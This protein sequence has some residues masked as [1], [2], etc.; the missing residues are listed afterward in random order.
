VIDVGG[1]LMSGRRRHNAWAAIVRHV[2]RQHREVGRGWEPLAEATI[3]VEVCLKQRVIA[4]VLAKTGPV[5]G[6]GQ[7]DVV[8]MDYVHVPTH[9]PHLESKDCRVITVVQENES[10]GITICNP[11]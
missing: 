5:I 8:A 7:V 4:Y 11:D 10:D 3:E 6:V 9:Q 2:L 1:L